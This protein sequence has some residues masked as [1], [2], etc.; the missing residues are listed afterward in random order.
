MQTEELELKPRDPDSMNVI[1]SG[2]LR[3]GVIVSAVL[4]A[5]GTV[6]LL[7]RSGSAEV[8]GLATYN[9]A[10]VPHGNFDPSLGLLL[11]GLAT[12]DSQSIIELGVLVL[13][14]TPAARVLFSVLLFAAEGDRL[15]AYITAVVLS[16][17]LFSM[18]ATPFIPGFNR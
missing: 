15:Y 11:K 14:A 17:L 1:I 2:V 12:M 18:L 16:L 8:S 4:I 9:P 3:Y 6:L 5:I 7:L 10:R 13:L